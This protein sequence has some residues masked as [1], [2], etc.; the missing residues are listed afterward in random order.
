MEVSSADVT[1]PIS[2]ESFAHNTLYTLAGLRLSGVA[3]DGFSYQLSG[4]LQYKERRYGSDLRGSSSIVQLEAFALDIRDA[5]ANP[6]FVGSA[7]L[8]Y[9]LGKDQQITA[10]LAMRGPLSDAPQVFKA[11]L[12]YQVSF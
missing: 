11:A 2:Y 1:N 6:E 9:H 5:S 7:D 10:T 12:G 3:T 8:R 4:G